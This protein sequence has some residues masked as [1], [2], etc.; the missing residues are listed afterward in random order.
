MEKRLKTGTV[1]SK[2]CT[3]FLLSKNEPNSVGPKAFHIDPQYNFF[4]LLKFRC[5]WRAPTLLAGTAD[6]LLAAGIQKAAEWV[7]LSLLP[8][9]RLLL[10]HRCQVTLSVGKQQS[11]GHFRPIS[12]PRGL[13]NASGDEA[14]DTCFLLSGYRV[15]WLQ[16]SKGRTL[17]RSEETLCI[18]QRSP[19]EATCN[20]EAYMCEH[21]IESKFK[22]LWRPHKSHQRMKQAG[23]KIARDNNDYLSQYFLAIKLYHGSIGS[24]LIFLIERPEIW[25]L[26]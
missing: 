4:F 10:R 8:L 6:V 14:E 19:P 2:F 3:T 15:G 17:H 11:A 20:I 16:S 9:H 18:I 23:N 26:R 22:C 7:P 24:K 12:W 13:P 25:I 5:F 21:Y 1:P